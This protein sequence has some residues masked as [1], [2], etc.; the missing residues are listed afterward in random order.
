MLNLSDIRGKLRNPLL[1][2]IDLDVNKGFDRFGEG[3]YQFLLN[4]D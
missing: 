4:Q 2:V 1:A 3:Q